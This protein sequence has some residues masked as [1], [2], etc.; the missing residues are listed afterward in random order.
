MFTIMSNELK[1]KKLY[2]VYLLRGNQKILIE[3]AIEEIRAKHESAYNNLDYLIFD[4]N[5][6]ELSKV[7]DNAN[8]YSMFYRKKLIVLKNAHKLKPAELSM[9]NDYINN[10]SP[11]AS[12]IL[13]SENANKPSLKKNKNIFVQTFSK[14]GNISEL[15][16]KEAL[17]LGIS[18]TADAALLIQNMLGT[19]L[20][21][22]SGE[23]SK[24]LQFYKDKKTLETK[25]ITEFLTKRSFCNTFELTNALSIK[26]KRKAL[27]ALKELETQNIEP[28]SILGTIVWKFR[29]IL[30]IK[31]YEN[32]RN[33]KGEITSEMEISPAA[34]SYL[35]SQA[36]NF[37]PKELIEIIH[38]L[39]TTELK[40][41]STHTDKYGLISNLIIDICR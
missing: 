14:K 2:P 31:S 24:L 11:H 30:Q 15:I 9:I 41:K 29:Q 39:Y 33:Y 27:I 18:I 37:S 32:I 16:K 4:S 13:T 12:I 35:R 36:K 1:N 21:V 10:P 40:L 20:M 23:L 7:L 17:L 5:D 34:I 8:T 6:I 22:I 3:R 26:N 38:L 19:D 28:I 25:D